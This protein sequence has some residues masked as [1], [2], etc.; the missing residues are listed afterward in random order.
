MKKFLFMFLLFLMSCSQN[1]V[2]SN[3][4]FDNK[5]SFDEFKSKL[6]E[7]AKNNPYPNIDN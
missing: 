6:Y 5:M 3:I 2:R 4:D 1:A 7:Y